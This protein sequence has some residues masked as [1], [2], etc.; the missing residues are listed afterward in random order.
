LPDHITPYDRFAFSDVDI[1]R[2]LAT[3]HMREELTAYF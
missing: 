2:M 3:D 1:E